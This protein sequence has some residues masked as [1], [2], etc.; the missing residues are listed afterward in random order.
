MNEE[1]TYLVNLLNK[2]LKGFTKKIDSFLIFTGE[3]AGM[4]Q[5]F[6]FRLVLFKLF[7]KRNFI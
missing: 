1:Q 3:K 7:V 6:V 5:V 2:L 4:E